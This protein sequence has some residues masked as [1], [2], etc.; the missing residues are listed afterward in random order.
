MAYVINMDAFDLAQP[1][2][3]DA[4]IDPV[5]EPMMVEE[6]NFAGAVEEG[7]NLFVNVPPPPI[8]EDV[9]INVI[10]NDVVN[11][12]EGNEDIMMNVDAALLAVLRL[13][14]RL[15][16]RNLNAPLDN[17]LAQNL[18][19]VAQM[20]GAI[21]PNNIA[22]PL[23]A[24]NQQAPGV[25]PPEAGNP[26]QVVAEANPAAPAVV[27]NPPAEQPAEEENLQPNRINPLLDLGQ[28]LTQAQIQEIQ[29]QA[30]S[31]VRNKVALRERT[32]LLERG[33]LTQLISYLKGQFK[34]TE[35]M[36]E[37]IA[38]KAMI[39]TTTIAPTESILMDNFRINYW[40]WNLANDF[41]KGIVRPGTLSLLLV[42]LL[43]LI[44]FAVFS[45]VGSYH[46]VD[47]FVGLLGFVKPLWMMTH[48]G[49]MYASNNSILE[50]F[51]FETWSLGIVNHY[52]YNFSLFNLLYNVI[53]WV[54]LLLLVHSFWKFCKIW[55]EKFRYLLGG[56]FTVPRG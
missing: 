27:Q 9:M 26:A 48:I 37:V 19:R 52:N 43:C 55:R 12:A 49:Y 16:T 24:A 18:V 39:E 13:R 34:L 21:A 46:F 8:M 54:S 15:R 44:A 40:D 53:A 42:T 1:H 14:L 7:Q 41:A 17:E 23:P 22:P 36:C 51:T 28:Q 3:Q 25:V 10:Q 33:I 6:G 2:P 29:S 11:Y 38:S 45:S 32:M 35:S 31:F 50:P 56:T 47:G 20:T 4:I 5:Q 30:N